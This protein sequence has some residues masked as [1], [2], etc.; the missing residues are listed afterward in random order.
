MN[1]EN[2]V[3]AITYKPRRS[4]DNFIV[5]YWGTREEVDAEWA[6][7]RDVLGFKMAPRQIVRMSQ[8]E[9]EAAQ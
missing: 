5:D 9:A 8:A 1:K 7:I 3:W 2:Q 4:S 6:Y